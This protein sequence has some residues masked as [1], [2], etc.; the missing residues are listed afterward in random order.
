M[1]TCPFSLHIYFYSNPKIFNYTPEEVVKKIGDDY[2]QMIH[3]QS[4]TVELWSKEL[5]TC[6][7]HLIGF[8][9]AFLWWDGEKGVKLKLLFPKEKILCDYIRALI[10]IISY[11]TF[12]KSLMTQWYNDETILID[13]I[14]LVL[15][16]IVQTQNIN[17]YFQS[18]T[19]LSDILL[20]LVELNVFSRI[21]LCAYGILSGTLTDEH[22][23]EL[24]ITNN[25][26]IV[27]FDMLEQA[28]HD[29]SKRYKQIPINYLLNGLIISY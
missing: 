25:I 21:Y 27:F 19:H 10:R 1:K 14:L 3:N 29:P 20:K 18:M 26:G 8:M 16:N 22:L 4:Y 23:K 28:W 11:Q 12:Y 24:K 15:M 6:I 2:L 5:F 7:A 13:S 17:W 9:R